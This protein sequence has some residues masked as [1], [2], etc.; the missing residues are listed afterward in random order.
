MSSSNG[1]GGK[2]SSD[3]PWMSGS[4]PESSAIH[5]DAGNGIGATVYQARGW[6]S[7]VRLQCRSTVISGS[8]FSQRITWR[9]DQLQFPHGHGCKLEVGDNGTGRLGKLGSSSGLAT[10]PLGGHGCN[11]P[12]PRWW[13]GLSASCLVNGFSEASRGGGWFTDDDLSLEV[14]NENGRRVVV[15]GGV[16]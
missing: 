3:V 4:A 15:V 7:P 12:Q 5:M 2:R 13:R 14:A 1:G 8:W 16:A 9:Q 6:L 10:G 11:S